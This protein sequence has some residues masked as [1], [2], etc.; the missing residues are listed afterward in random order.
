MNTER[1][2]LIANMLQHNL[3]QLIEKG[4]AMNRLQEEKDLEKRQE[5]AIIIP[6]EYRNLWITTSRIGSEIQKV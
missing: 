3:S 2:I 6:S 4:N 1:I 5:L